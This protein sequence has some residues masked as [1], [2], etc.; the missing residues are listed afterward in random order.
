MAGAAVAASS[1]SSSSPAYHSLAVYGARKP[2]AWTRMATKTKL[3]KMVYDV[4]SAQ[5]GMDWNTWKG[6]LVKA[7]ERREE[8][9]GIAEYFQATLNPMAAIPGG[10]PHERAIFQPG[11]TAFGANYNWTKLEQ[12]T[13][14][15]VGDLHPELSQ[16]GPRTAIIR[17]QYMSEDVT[18]DWS[19]RTLQQVVDAAEGGLLQLQNISGIRIWEIITGIKPTKQQR[20]EFF[21]LILQHAERTNSRAIHPVISHLA[22]PALTTADRMQWMRDR[23]E[24]NRRAQSAAF[25][26]AS[27]LPPDL[28][29]LA[30]SYYTSGIVHEDG[31][32]AAAAH[33]DRHPRVN[34]RGTAA[35]E[36]QRAM[37][38]E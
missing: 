35:E 12:T 36:A 27:S 38:D 37:L 6:L 29:R 3:D 7:G 21:E 19:S 11:D 5:W 15:A 22:N 30:G 33:P 1:S 13:T 10:H 14:E 18:L 34:M 25:L 9:S 28:A 26:A 23:V 20:E 8:E 24:E 31:S 17:P 16:P 32:G 2:T 4:L